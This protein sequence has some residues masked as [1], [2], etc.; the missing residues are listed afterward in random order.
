MIELSTF[1]SEDH[2]TRLRPNIMLHRT[3]KRN[4]IGI[5][6]DPNKKS[7]KGVVLSEKALFEQAK[8][9]MDKSYV[10]DFVS[11]FPNVTYLYDTK[12]KYCPKYS[13]RFMLIEDGM[14]KFMEIVFPIFLIAAMNHLNVLNAAKALNTDEDVDAVDYLN[15]SATLALAVVVFLPTMI[16]TSRFHSARKVQSFIQIF[17]FGKQ[18][19]A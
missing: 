2:R 8:D 1:T 19:V 9:K 16:G 13:M 14:Q 7:K 15:N 5:Q 17:C 4:M 6:K 10:Y 12:K 18:L 11:P 3:E